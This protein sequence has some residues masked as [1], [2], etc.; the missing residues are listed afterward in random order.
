M[1]ISSSLRIQVFINLLMQDTFVGCAV[2]LKT[3]LGIKGKGKLIDVRG[4]LSWDLSNN[5]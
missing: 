4:K 1:H 5:L 3:A 2:L